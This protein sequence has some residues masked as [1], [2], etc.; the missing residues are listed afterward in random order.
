MLLFSGPFQSAWAVLIETESIIKAKQNRIA[1]EYVDN[2]L[3]R[4]EIRLALLSQGINPQEAKARIDSLSDAEVN[5]IANKLDQLPA[6]AG[7]MQTS[8]IIALLLFLIFVI[9]D[10]AGILDTPD[11]K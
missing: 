7:A 4:E 1:R 8:L 6:P 2:L 11:Q 3:T 10:I 5:E 9:M